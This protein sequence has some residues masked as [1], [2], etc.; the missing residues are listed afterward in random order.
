M[1][2]SGISAAPN[3]TGLS[4]CI[5]ACKDLSL[6]M[7]TI[8]QARS[9]TRAGHEV[10][11]VGFRVPDARLAGED[12]VAILVAT[13]TPHPSILMMTKLWVTHHVLRDDAGL[14]CSAEAFVAAGD[15]R[16]GLFTRRAMAALKDRSFDVVQA[17][18]DRSLIAGAA[19]AQSCGAK[20]VFDA[21]EIPF[22][23]EMLP[24]PPTT[25]AVRLAEIRREAEI[26]RR[27]D[28]WI[29]V[30]D[31]LADD[32]MERF[33]LPRPLVL[34]NFQDEGP[35][36]SDGRLRSDA[37]LTDDARI[38]LHLNT[39]RPGEGVE[40]GIDAL[41]YLPADFHLVALGPVPERGFL[42][43]I[44][45][46]A[47]AR[48]AAGRFHIAPLQPP[49]A[50]LPYIAG[51]D[52]GIIARQGGRQNFRLSLPNRLFQLIAARLPV[53]ATRLPEI[54]RIVE[55]RGIGL[56]FDEADPAGLAA[57]VVKIM[58]PSALAGY[59]EAADRAARAFTWDRESAAYVRFIERS[60]QGLPLEA[61][62]PPQAALER[63]ARG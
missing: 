35:W 62:S 44:R 33:D 7:R 9:L 53:V 55:S 24:K 31:A 21:V 47:V 1:P 49:H 57:A 39:M 17:H 54:A 14:E 48:G 52:I 40:T 28:G 22:D 56:L 58:E 50:V 20:L 6:N 36:R 3:Q 30:N 26:A 13:G 29:T 42:R 32:A 59:R 16:G 2:E 60:A 43:R 41:A 11:I 61:E 46:Y 5:I 8:R 51:A 34:R 19:L 37:G 63:V 23:R 4:V 27:A 15:S 10:T 12:E 25:R 38:L 45:R 18:F